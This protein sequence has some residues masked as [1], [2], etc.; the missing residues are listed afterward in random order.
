MAALLPPTFL[1]PASAAAVRPESR[2][3]AHV[4]RRFLER[5]GLPRRDPVDTDG[6][7]LPRTAQ[8]ARFRHVFSPLVEHGLEFSERNAAT[9]GLGFA[10]PWSD[11]RIAEFA[12]SCPQHVLDRA[13]D[14]KRL[15][16]RALLGVMPTDA[17]NAARKVSPGPWYADTLRGAAYATVV[18]LITGSRCA[19]FG[20]IDETRLRDRFELFVRG[21]TPVFDLWS[22]I[23]LEVWLRR[24]WDDANR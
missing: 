24:Y 22:T 19:E 23:S 8:R 17:I 3:A 21:E 10:D 20:F 11:R 6:G 14:A 15:A 9:F 4:D 1:P 13:V 12:L 5:A 7:F 16:R 18:E 2:A